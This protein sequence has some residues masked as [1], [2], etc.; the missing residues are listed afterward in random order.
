MKK[1]NLTLIGFLS[2][3]SLFAQN[4]G[5]GTTNP[6]HQ[7]HVSSPALSNGALRSILVETDT[8]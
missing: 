2:I 8:P 7:L 6:S 4:V 1:I 5:I 3:I